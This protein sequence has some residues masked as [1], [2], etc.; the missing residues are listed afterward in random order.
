MD[1]KSQVGAY[2]KLENAKAEVDKRKGQGYHVFDEKGHAIYP[3]DTT[4]KSYKVRVSIKDLYI[5]T[6]LG[7]NYNKRGFIEPNVYLNQAEYSHLNIFNVG[8]G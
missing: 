6:G 8:G 2:K 3:E 7:T 5:R 1:A 4:F